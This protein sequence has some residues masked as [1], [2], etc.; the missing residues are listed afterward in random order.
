MMDRRSG[1]SQFA[2]VGMALAFGFMA[3][4]LEALT[5]DARGMRFDLS[6]WTVIAFLAGA[7]VG[8]FYWEMAMK[9]NTDAEHSSARARRRFIVFSALLFVGGFASYLYRLRFVSRTSS[10]EVA[11]GVVLAFVVV[12]AIGVVMW[13]IGRYLEGK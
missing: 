1:W 9:M 7:A 4:S 10:W 6:L 2:R 13:R 11:E 5:R 8:W 12:A 3:G